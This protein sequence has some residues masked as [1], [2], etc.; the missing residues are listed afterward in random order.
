MNSQNKV[1]M[2]RILTFSHLFLLFSTIASLDAYTL[3]LPLA[4]RSTE[5]QDLHPVNDGSVVQNDPQPCSGGG[6][7]LNMINKRQTTDC[8]GMN[9]GT[10]DFGFQEPQ[11]SDNQPGRWSYPFDNQEESLKVPVNL[12]AESHEDLS[13]EENDVWDEFPWNAATV[14]LFPSSPNEQDTPDQM[15]ASISDVKTDDT[16]NG[17]F[18][19]A[20]KKKQDSTIEQAPTFEQDLTTGFVLI[21]ASFRL[22]AC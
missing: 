3:S 19:I 11:K 9:C 16:G 15:E 7:L 14:N 5:A 20:A 12:D 10:N 1:I 22:S 6:P 17:A 18:E 13:G 4:I 2:R 8:V 21:W